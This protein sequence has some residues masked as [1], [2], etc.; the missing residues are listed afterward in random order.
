MCKLFF[1]ICITSLFCVCVVVMPIVVVRQR[2]PWR[3]LDGT[4][5]Y[6]EDNAC[7]ITNPKGEM[8]GSQITGPVCKE[9]AELWPK[10]SSNSDAIV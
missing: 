6:M 10:V 9:A 7:I 5:I 1:C 2:R 8:K 3:R 4:F